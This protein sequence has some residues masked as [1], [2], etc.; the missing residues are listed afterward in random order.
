MQGPVDPEL[1][2]YPDPDREENI[3]GKTCW[4]FSGQGPAGKVKGWRYPDRYSVTDP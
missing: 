4:K 1:F 2:F 3:P